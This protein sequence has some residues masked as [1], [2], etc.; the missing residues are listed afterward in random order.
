MAVRIKQRR[1]TF[2]EWDAVKDSAVLA[3]GEI[4]VEYDPLDP[5]NQRFKVGNG[6]DA[7]T[8][9]NYYES[10]EAV[11]TEILSLSGLSTLE[12]LSDKVLPSGG[13]NDQILAKTSSSDY[14]FAWQS[15]SDLDI[16]LNDLS[17]VSTSGAVADNTILFNGTS[18]I[19]GKPIGR[20]V[21]VQSTEPTGGE[22]GDLWFW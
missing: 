22:A 15:P 4:G 11:L 3:N 1:G 19:V 17:N 21:Y 10:A 2:A 7:W 6:V 14:E 20:T 16:T 13:A 8:D 5:E 12:G 9:L 18:W